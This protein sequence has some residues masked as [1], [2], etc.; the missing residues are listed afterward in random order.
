M[1][2]ALL[3]LALAVATV[4]SAFAALP[5]S[6]TVK[7][8]S[9]GPFYLCEAY[10]I[11]A[12]E[13]GDS[14]SLNGKECSPNR[15]WTGAEIVNNVCEPVQSDYYNV[16]A[17]PGILCLGERAIDPMTGHI[18]VDFDIEKFVCIPE[19][20][21]RPFIQSWRFV[22]VIGE[23]DKCPATY[24]GRT[25]Y[26]FGDEQVRTWWTLLYTSP[27]TTFTLLI[28]GVCQDGFGRPVLFKNTWTWQVLATWESL[29]AAVDVFHTFPVGTCE[30]PCFSAEEMYVAVRN[31]IV[32]LADVAADIDPNTEEG[33][34]AR[35]DAQDQLFA[36]EAMITGFSSFT[37]CFV[38]E[39]CF[40]EQFPP[41]D[42]VQFGDFG[43]TGM[44]DTIE[45]PCV[46]KLIADLEFLGEELD[47]VSP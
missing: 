16:K 10:P 47:I 45:N 7:E 35:V 25:F 3:S 42:S 46:C 12:I 9:F 32:D 1:K 18:S 28:T 29:I 40:S 21:A 37:D 8:K 17:V 41:A 15:C 4:S 6:T 44:I 13:E 14:G 31:A 36:L 2:K 30:V 34:Q 26:L 11:A 38:P 19:D 39:E 43:Y 5:G 20:C 27:K 33:R 24:G 23:S 22:K